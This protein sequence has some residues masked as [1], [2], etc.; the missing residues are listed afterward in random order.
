MAGAL[1][2][3]I[4]TMAVPYAYLT[5]RKHRN[6]IQARVTHWQSEYDLSDSD[7][8]RLLEIELN[9]HRYEYVLSLQPDPT[10]EQIEAHSREVAELLGTEDPQHAIEALP[11]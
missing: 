7:T 1:L 10:P 3:F 4:V 5:S 2:F 9:F 8:R 11:D 6:A